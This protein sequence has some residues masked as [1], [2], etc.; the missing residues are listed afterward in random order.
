MLTGGFSA[1]GAA[2][3]Q[4]LAATAVEGDL[5]GV[6]RGIDAAVSA[7][8]A[9]PKDVADAALSLALLQARGD[10]RLWGKIFEKAGALKGG[11]DAASLTAF[12]WAAT[13]ANVGHFKTAFDLAAPATKLLGSFTPAQLATVVEALGKAGVNDPDF[14]KGVSDRLTKGAADFSASELAKLLWGG[15]AAG[16]ADSTYAK[17]AAGA[18]VSKIGGASAKDAA[19]AAWALAKLGRVDKPVLDALGKALGAK[20]GAGDAPADAAAAVW[21]FATLNYKLDAQALTKATA[22]IKAGAAELSTEQAIHAAWGLALLGSADKDALSALLTAAGGA[23]AAAPDSVSVQA[24][25]ALCEAQTL[26]LDRLGAQGPKVSDQVYAYTQGLYTLVADAA[27]A[28]RPAAAAAF[29]AAVATAAARAGGAR[30]KPEIAAAVAALPRKTPDGLPVEFG[31][32][33]GS[34]LKVGADLC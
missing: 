19:Q 8:N 28:R 5:E 21:A 18:L 4:P 11:F 7:E 22:A 31:L 13:T 34:D 29:R 1:S 17:A 20:L 12:L 15:A 33:L 3:A 9:G 32:D 27:K 24:A 16:A 23:I 6:L 2:A 14:F 30:Y 26:I 10:R 25:A